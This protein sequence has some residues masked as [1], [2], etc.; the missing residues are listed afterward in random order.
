MK[1]NL[2]R[3]LS[4]LLSLVLVL[5]TFFALDFVDAAATTKGGDNITYT[6]SGGVLT[7]TG[8]GPMYDF[9]ASNLGSNKKPPWQDKNDTITK[10]IV[11]SGIT[12]I[13]DY[14]FYNCVNLK[15]VQLPNTIE[16]I[17]GSGT[18]SLSYGAFQGCTALTTINFPEGLKQIQY[19]A[20]KGCTSLNNITFPSTLEEIQFSAFYQC[21]S[22]TSVEFPDS[23]TKIG[24]NAFDS[25]KKL[26][27]VKYG[28]GL[29]STGTDVFREAGVKYIDFGPSI[30]TIDSYTFYGCTMTSIEIPEQITSIGIRA[31]GDT[32]YL[33][34]AYVYNPNVEYRGIIGEDPFNAGNRQ[35]NLTMYGNSGSTTQTYAETKGYNFVSIDDCEHTN[36][37]EV[38]V[39]KPTCTTAGTKNVVC[40][41]CDKVVRT[42]TMEALG[43]TYETIQADDKTKENGH[44]IKLNECV[45]CKNQETVIE[46]QLLPKEE[47]D[48]T[49]GTEGGTGIGGNIG[50][51][52]SGAGDAVNPHYVWVDGFYTYT[53]SATCRLPGI[54]IY[55]CT[56]EGCET[57]ERNA[58]P[59]GN[60]AV[61]NWTV[62]EK[63]T[64]TED[65]E[66]TGKCT[67]CGEQAIETI[68]ATGHNFPEE[69]KS[70]SDKTKEDGHTYEVFTCTVCKEDVSF[71]THVEWIEG[72]FTP[73]VI[74]PAHCVINGLEIDTCDIC[75]TRRSVTLEANGEHDWY[76]TN[77][78]EPTCTAVGKIFYACHNCNMTKSENIEAL[79]HDYIIDENSCKA[80]TCTSVGYDTYSCS[81]C[82]VSKQE[83]VPATGHTP[84]DGTLVIMTQVTCENDGAEKGHCAVCDK[85]YSVVIKALGH[86]YQ[87]VLR[88]MV[89][90]PG[91]SYSTPTCTRC[92]ATLSSESVHTEWV[93]GYY[94]TEVT[95]EAGCLVQE[96]TKYTCTYCSTEKYEATGAPLGH[97]YIATGAITSNGSISYRCEHCNTITIQNP[98]NVMAMWD[99]DYLFMAGTN[100]TAVDNTSLIDANGDGF[101][102]AKDYALL[103]NLC[104]V[105][106]VPDAPVEPE[107]EGKAPTMEQF[108]YYHLED[109]IKAGITYTDEE[110]NEVTIPGVKDM[111]AE[112]AE[113]AGLLYNKVAYPITAWP[114]ALSSEEVP[115]LN[116]P[117][118]QE[119]PYGAMNSP[120]RYYYCATSNGTVLRLLKSG[121][122]QIAT[123]QQAIALPYY[124]AYL[125]ANGLE[126]DI[127]TNITQR[128]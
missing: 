55:T 113:E 7:L 82:S 89:S 44:I 43:H 91:H 70:T 83:A 86:D 39:V 8:S 54:E 11:N 2:K 96:R 108:I 19:C 45:T 73:N 79:G 23:L 60:H 31:F 22:I 85:D 88:P 97:H 78:T 119:D 41:R 105:A 37:H 34:K 16:S 13:G 92:R 125:I 40:D 67:K 122:A 111:T 103:R 12:T 101:I 20:F 126:L 18:Q 62:T 118:V 98:H 25:C 95:V 33:N 107:E 49:E 102:N 32:Y 63:A 28:A 93:D 76:E 66:R 123:A 77:Q 72:K 47:T 104:K 21:E 80:P 48:T 6:L 9:R 99:N 26:S 56:Y 128:D 3:S 17:H 58:S 109:T 94:T 81:R 14:S 87:E 52:I 30:T 115:A 68:P 27:R 64:C 4:L 57:V 29:T 36:T 15:E 75:G 127:E 124:Q 53:N 46:H 74:T 65:G 69:P 51:A 71:P 61:D 116:D 24:L 42:L 90:H 120:L 10:V 117:A 110:G 35:V 50:G 59:R 100:R 121:S 106:P 84:V 114:V 112:E 38:V 1:K 5:S